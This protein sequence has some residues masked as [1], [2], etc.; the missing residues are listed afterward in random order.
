MC[1]YG[2]MT[3]AAADDDVAAD[4]HDD[5]ADD[6]V[7]FDK[8]ADEDR[9]KSRIRC[10]KVKSYVKH[11]ICNKRLVLFNARERLMELATRDDDDVF[12]DETVDLA[13][14]SFIE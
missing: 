8:L 11:D 14:E 2:D 3:D 7:D 5:D 9:H 6:G 13:N 12:V 1:G 10:R 4:N